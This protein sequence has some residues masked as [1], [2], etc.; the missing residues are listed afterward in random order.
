MGA[1]DPPRGQQKAVARDTH[2]AL[3]LPWVCRKNNR[4]A[5]GTIL[6]LIGLQAALTATLLSSAPRAWLLEVT[7]VGCDLC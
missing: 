3:G 2:G 6:L 7:A 1:A 5:K 4:F